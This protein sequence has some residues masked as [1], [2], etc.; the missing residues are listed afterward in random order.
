MDDRTAVSEIMTRLVV[1]TTP[2]AR[3]D[4]A[5]RLLREHHVSGLPVVDPPYR[6]VGVLSERDLVRTL[7]RAAG[8]ASARGLLDLLLESA[9]AKGESALEVCRSHLKN[10]RVG[11][12]MT[13]SVVTIDRR[14]TIHEAAR[15]MRLHGVKRLPVLDDRQHLVGIVTREDVV[16]AI[17]GENRRARGSLHPAPESARGEPIEVTGPYEDI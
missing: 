15:L 12:V 5:A 7:H 11:D 2:D 9:P 3:L 1:S 10:T 13:R 14:A 8:V 17:S 4:Q 6:V 16:R